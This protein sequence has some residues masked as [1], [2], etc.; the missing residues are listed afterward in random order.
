MS[1][2]PE[3]IYENAALTTDAKKELLSIH[4][5]KVIKKG[6]DLL[7][8]G[9]KSNHYWIVEEG[10]LRSFVISPNG[11]DIT[12]NFYSAREIAMEF[13]GFFLRKHSLEA[14]QALTESVVWEVNFDDFSRFMKG[15]GPFGTWGREWMVN[16]LVARQ[17]FHLSVHT[18]A[19][20]DRYE[21]LVK[22]RP[23]VIRLSPLKHIVSY[24]GVTD[25]TLSRLRK[26]L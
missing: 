19:A 11:D 9:A 13:N 17:Q 1:S 26:H 15:N 7:K 14:M 3:K 20:R 5:R 12:T 10:L 25:S 21:R 8:L 2:F 18:D 22:E 23:E 16:Y 4:H 24:L 6:E